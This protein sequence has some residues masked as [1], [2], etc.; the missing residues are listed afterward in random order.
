MVKKKRHPAAARRTI[1][2]SEIQGLLQ[3]AVE[4]RRQMRDTVLQLQDDLAWLHNQLD[5]LKEQV[6]VKTYPRLLPT[7]L[8]RS[9]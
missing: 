2:I 5:K 6:S 8:P 4:E 1:A 7:T 9:P 3:D